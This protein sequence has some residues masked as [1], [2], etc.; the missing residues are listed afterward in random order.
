[1]RP[2]DLSF[3]NPQKSIGK[4]PIMSSTHGKCSTSV[5]SD[6]TVLPPLMGLLYLETTE[7]VDSL[8]ALEFDKDEYPCVP[9]NVME[10]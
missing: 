1:M 10:L 4:A 3:S 5:G 8:E 9:E 2:M 6:E 7:E